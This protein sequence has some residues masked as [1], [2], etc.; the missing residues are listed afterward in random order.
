MDTRKIPNTFAIHQ[1]GHDSG[2]DLASA[3]WDAEYEDMLDLTL[4]GVMPASS[5][6]SSVSRVTETQAPKI[7]Q[8]P[9]QGSPSPSPYSTMQ[10]FGEHKGS[11]ILSSSSDLDQ[12]D[13]A[14]GWGTLS[15]W[16]N[17]AVSTVSEV[18]EN[19]NVVVSKAHTLGQGLRNVAT[20][21][22]DRVYESLDPEY[23]YQK[24]RQLKHEQQQ[25]I[26]QPEQAN[27]LWVSSRPQDRSSSTLPRQEEQQTASESNECSTPDRVGSLH[28]QHESP[29]LQTAPTSR[30]KSSTL[31]TST[32][33][34]LSGGN[35][36]IKDDTTINSGD[37]RWEDDAWGDN[38]DTPVEMESAT[39][40]S[41]DL[42][43]QKESSA[44]A[45]DHD[46]ARQLPETRTPLP[47]IEPQNCQ[48]YDEQVERACLPS[49][50][51]NVKDLFS[52]ES[53]ATSVTRST[54]TARNLA[55]P[56][57]HQ[58]NDQPEQPSQRRPS[59]DLRPAEALF[60]TL[61]FASNAL[62]SAVLEVHR[63][64]TQASQSQSSKNNVASQLR[65]TSPAWSNT[66]QPSSNEPPSGREVFDKMDRLT[67]TNPSLESVGG[68]VVSTGLGA[69]ESLGKRAVDAISDVRR[70]GHLS[71]AQ[72]GSHGFPDTSEDVGPYKIPSTMNLASL[73][74]G[75]GGRAHLVSMRSVAS[76]TT[77]R[78]AALVANRSDLQEMGQ[79][80]ELEE[81]LGPISLDSAV[82]DLTVDILAGHKDFRSM[83]S[84]LEKMGVQGTSHLRLLRNGTRKLT[85]LVPDSVNAFEQEWHN[86]QSRASER[87]FFARLP[88]R[89]FFESRLLS[90]YFDGI[91]SISQ[92]THRTCDQALKLTEN[93]HSRLAEKI[94]SS[95]PSAP[96]V[97]SIGVERPPPLLLA[98]LLQQFLGSLIAE[99]R[100]ITKMYCMTLDAVLQTA[101]GFT[102]PLDRL[103][104]EDLAMGTHNVKDKLIES[105]S[106]EAVG[107]IHSGAICIM[108]VLKN[109][110][111]VDVLQGKLVPKARVSRPKQLELTPVTPAL[112]AFLS[113]PTLFTKTMAQSTPSSTLSVTTRILRS[114]SLE[115]NS[116]QSP[117]QT[118]H[119]GHVTR[120]RVL[121]QPAA[122]AGTSS[123][124]TP[125]L[126]DTTH[127]LLSAARRP[128]SASS[129]N[130]SRPTQSSA[131]PVL[132]DE[133]FFSILNETSR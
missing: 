108:G 79:F 12:K 50:T 98:R 61:D 16:I 82:A 35:L 106:Q 131:R 41:T 81:V 93:F 100:F 32:K 125:G 133:D 56:P 126:K 95:V 33:M 76:T 122:P 37:D 87:D 121:S 60:S 29:G 74:E 120:A 109:E 7:P 17:T 104:W 97:S 31:N 3:S 5:K 91:R 23:E 117:G 119:K 101:K 58:E 34:A 73:F 13:A 124:M 86:H 127:P 68:N 96:G 36:I 9:F 83:V 2:D 49:D 54:A 71:H 103:D 51:R 114:S 15:S 116:E 69:L 20:E 48:G 128:S 80:D 130:V 64:V 75:A 53:P 102:T 27:Q 4:T 39:S 18:I 24:E 85:T 47:P 112:P 132:R 113:S 55:L 107:F 89:K 67:L 45:L 78:V 43:L 59:S 99:L 8:G 115:P 14:R 118:Q 28:S 72:N 57:V 25:Q 46:S 129:Q 84:L 65:P 11:N 77:S 70:A 6:P 110:L 90:I 19:P 1:S 40:V 21:Q 26:H 63:K 105:D 22:I 123:P 88:I 42:V 38:W 30:S 10:N 44:A 66:Q 111:I 92:F 62:G 52:M 94:D